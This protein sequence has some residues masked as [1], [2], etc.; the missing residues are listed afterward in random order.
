MDVDLQNVEEFNHSLN[1][2]PPF[3]R[4]AYFN[5]YQLSLKELDYRRTSLN[6]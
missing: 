1:F 2:K 5:Y 6:S 4:D 3:Y